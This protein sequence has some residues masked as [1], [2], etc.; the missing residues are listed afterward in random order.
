[1]L[2]DHGCHLLPVPRSCTRSRPLI[3]ADLPTHRSS[4]G[5]MLQSVS[6][7]KALQLI[8]QEAVNS[9]VLRH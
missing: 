7:L 5:A 1:M 8:T 2:L 9:C 4:A 6:K 3:A